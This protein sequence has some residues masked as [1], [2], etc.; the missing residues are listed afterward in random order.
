MRPPRPE[1]LLAEDDPVLTALLIEFLDQEGYDVISAADG[2]SALHYAI[3]HTPAAILLDG[4]MP[5]LDGFTFARIYQALPGPHA[6]V[7]FIT[8]DPAACREQA[9]PHSVDVLPKPF[10]LDGLLGLLEH[11]ISERSTVSLLPLAV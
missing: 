8:G 6:P 9:L 4:H 1:L 3:R 2:L 11:V 10:A 5:R 7:V